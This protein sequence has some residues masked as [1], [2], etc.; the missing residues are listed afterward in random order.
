MHPSVGTLIGIYMSEELSENFVFQNSWCCRKFSL[1]RLNKDMAG[2]IY[3][4]ADY[5]I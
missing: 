3:N 2:C 4:S 1:I 5:L